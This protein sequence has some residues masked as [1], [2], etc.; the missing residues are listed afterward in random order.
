[1]AQTKFQVLLLGT[2]AKLLDAVS[3]AIQPTGAILT[4]SENSADL[5]RAVQK[6]TPDCVLLDLHSAA[7]ESLEWLK[8]RPSGH[9]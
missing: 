9:P 3:S 1:M 8:T 6:Q 7:A 5:M 2:N 4:F